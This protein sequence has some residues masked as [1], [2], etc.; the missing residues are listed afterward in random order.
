[1]T[2]IPRLSSITDHARGWQNFSVKG[3][4][5]NILGFAGQETKSRILYKYSY[6]KR[7]NIFSL[8]FID[9]IKI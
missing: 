8:I 3:Q 5:I 7:E 4:I 2:Y 9:E 6:T 1:M